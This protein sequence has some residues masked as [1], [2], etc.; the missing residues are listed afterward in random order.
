M[1]VSSG[2]RE[3]L[4]SCGH[5]KTGLCQLNISNNFSAMFL[6]FSSRLHLSCDDCLE[7][8]REDY[9]N[10][11]VLYCVQWLNYSKVG[12]GTLHFLPSLSLPSPPFP[13]LHLRSISLPCLPLEVGPVNPARGL[14]EHCKLPQ[15]GLGKSPSRNRIWCI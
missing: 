15:R 4:A 6:P 13:F 5:N 12:G 14:G 7:D 2:R 9:E 3:R 11:S 1:F 10:C 8:K